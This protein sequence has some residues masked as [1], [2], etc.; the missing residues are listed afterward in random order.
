MP[1]KILI[2]DDEVDLARNLQLQLEAQGY[3]TIVANEG[4]E[5]LRLAYQHQP[6]L[7]ILDLMMPGMSGYET[8]E[9]LRTMSEVPILMLTAMDSEDALVRGFSSGSDDY[10]TKPFRMRE[11]DMRIRALLR[12]GG[13]QATNTEV[14]NDG[15]LKIDLSTQQIF[16]TGQ[17]IHLTP[18]EFRLLECLVRNQGQVVH[19]DELLK[20]VWGTAYKSAT[21]LLSVYISYLR[22]KLEE[23][24]GEP[25]YILNK[26]GVG[27]WF[28]PREGFNN[29][30]QESQ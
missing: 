3:Q 19:H 9:H 4:R 14:Y 18:T 21:V 7:V 25:E 23:K 10:L 27:Y 1:A 5:G 17:E 2:I 24:P 22:D 16:R 8:C 30:N 29:P 28:A 26:W 13:R 12:R 15:N 6:D 11:L 20:R